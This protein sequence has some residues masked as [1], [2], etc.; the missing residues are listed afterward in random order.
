MRPC[1]RFPSGP[2]ADRKP[3]EPLSADACLSSA[4]AQ[5]C[6]ALGFDRSGQSPMTATVPIFCPG[7]SCPRYKC[8][9]RSQRKH[10]LIPVSSCLF[11]AV[12]SHDVAFPEFLPRIQTSSMGNTACQHHASWHHTAIASSF[13]PPFS[14]ARPCQLCCAATAIIQCRNIPT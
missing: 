4:K 12:S 13:F 6:S 1:V 10:L 8:S 5:Y 2:S 9:H 11:A 7:L 3:F 14:Y